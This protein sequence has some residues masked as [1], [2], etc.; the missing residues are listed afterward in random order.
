MGIT[1]ERWR[2]ASARCSMSARRPPSGRA[3]AAA[4]DHVRSPKR[5][6][7]GGEPFSGSHAIEYGC[8]VRD[9]RPHARDQAPLPPTLGSTPT[10]APRSSQAGIRMSTGWSCL[11][12]R[13]ANVATSLAA[14]GVGKAMDVP[15]RLDLLASLGEGHDLV[16]GEAVD[17]GHPVADG[18]PADPESFGETGSEFGFVEVS[19]GELVPV[20]ET[21]VDGP[22][23]I[24][25]TLD[26]VPHDHVGVELRIVRPAGELGEPRR[27]VPLGANR[28]SLN[29]IAGASHRHRGSVD[30]RRP[31]P[32]T[33]DAPRV[34]DATDSR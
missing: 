29:P 31:G 13:V 21:S 6:C 28:P 26:P 25:D 11:G 12:L 15:P 10:S 9:G 19:G 33:R 18:L 32:G 3:S 16:S 14:G 2:K 34:E 1:S 24:V 4:A 7:L 23:D 8:G 30:P 20:Q 17:V 27:H 22:P 5:R